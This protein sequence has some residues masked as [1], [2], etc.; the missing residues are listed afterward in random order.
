MH[1]DS[2]VAALL[3]AFIGGLITTFAGFGVAFQQHRWDKERREREHKELKHNVR[4]LLR[5]EINRNKE[6]AHAYYR[7][8]EEMPG[9][10]GVE[11]L[12]PKR[13]ERLLAKPMLP[14][15]RAMWEGQSQYLALTLER[16]ELENSAD[17]HVM[18]DRLSDQ[19][20]VFQEW[21]KRYREA[22]ANYAEMPASLKAEYERET[23]RLYARFREDLISI[24]QG[25][26]SAPIGPND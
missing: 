6:Q 25:P 5:L 21:Q 4:A 14:W 2:G 13:V 9:E 3:G 26:A 15:R 16:A 22:E 17:F 18:L 19:W 7:Y 1:M 23:G 24:F 11:L 8:L 12:I 10:S 20:A